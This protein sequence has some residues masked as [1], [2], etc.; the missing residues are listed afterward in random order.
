MKKI[1]VM[2]V[3]LFCAQSVRAQ[4]MAV[5]GVNIKDLLANTRA[6][7]WLPLQ[8]GQTFKTVYTP[9]IWAHSS[10]GVEYAALDVGGAAA[11]DLTKGCAFVALGFR[12]DN[13]LDR[14]LNLSGWIKTHIRSAKLPT[15][16]A[17][18]GPILYQ[19]KV[20][21]GASIAVRF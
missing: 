4:E 3:I 1:I 6:G 13:I 20:R 21:F 18:A 9:L 16:E 10:A 8:G 19:S 11:G 14:A 15:L 12:L 7:V 5:S 17:G 2:A